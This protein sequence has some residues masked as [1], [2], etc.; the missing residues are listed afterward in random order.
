VTAKLAAVAGAI[1]ALAA[2]APAGAGPAQT[3][4]PFGGTIFIDPDII[5]AEDPTTFR[6]LRYTGRGRREIFDRRT[7]RFVHV[8]AFLFR[9]AYEGGHPIEVVVNPEFA[10]V[11]A[12]RR[13][14]RF[15][16][17]PVGRLPRFLLTDVGQLWINRGK[18]PYGGGNGSLLIHIGQTA[19]YVRDGILEETLVHEATHTSVD[20]R[21]A[22]SKGWLAAQRSDPTFIS[23]YARENPTRE[24]VAETLLPWLAVRQRRDRIDASLA[25][26]IERAVPARLAYL[27]RQR[28]ALGPGF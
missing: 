10:S 18:Q 5:T 20:A 12:A 6:G 3:P 14:A 13:Q 11:K 17:G 4:P 9:A 22:A 26:T 16:A 7:D 23:D 27:D 28:F 8:R 21:H 1:V 24:D 2:A 19:E 15:Y 25:D